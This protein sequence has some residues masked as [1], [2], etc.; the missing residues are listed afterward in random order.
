MLSLFCA[1]RGIRGISAFRWTWR[2]KWLNMPERMN[3][4]LRWFLLVLGAAMWFGGM[5]AVYHFRDEVTRLTEA[6]IERSGYHGKADF[7]RIYDSHLAQTRGER[8][9]FNVVEVVGIGLFCGTLT[10][11]KADAYQRA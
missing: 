1:L 4:R 6:D 11:K 5:F 2:R 3:L 9:F 10:R 7:S 8:I